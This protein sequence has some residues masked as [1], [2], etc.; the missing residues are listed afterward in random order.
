MKQSREW[1]ETS[2]S[3]WRPRNHLRIDFGRI[4]SSI[5]YFADGIGMSPVTHPPLSY[6]TEKS[7]SCNLYTF[8]LHG[9][10]GKRR[11]EAGDG[12]GKKGGGS[13]ICNIASKPI[14][15]RCERLLEHFSWG[16][17]YFFVSL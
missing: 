6:F 9:G 14:E 15:L 8:A 3:C 1:V 16:C 11:D 10:E 4:F 13:I 2:A 7:Q 17:L 12:G 5:F